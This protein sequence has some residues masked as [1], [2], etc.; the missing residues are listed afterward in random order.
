MSDLFPPMPEEV[1]WELSL[2][3]G[4]AP[5]FEDNPDLCEE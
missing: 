5:E 2:P 3:D 4:E 1:E